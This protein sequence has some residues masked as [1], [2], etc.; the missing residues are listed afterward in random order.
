M[1]FASRLLNNNTIQVASEL[2]S[3]TISTTLHCHHQNLVIGL[4]AV[5]A[6]CTLS[7]FAGVYIEKILKKDKNI[8][9]WMQNIELGLMAIP[10]SLLVIAVRFI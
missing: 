6:V 7:G 8:S 10:F 9:I 5:L 2:N 4:L 3:S 1:S